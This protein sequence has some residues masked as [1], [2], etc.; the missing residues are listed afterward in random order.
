MG[1]AWPS[2]AHVHAPL[3]SP[4]EPAPPPV[5]PPPGTLQ[6]EGLLELVQVKPAHIVPSPRNVP[7]QPLADDPGSHTA[8][9]SASE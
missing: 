8:R 3:Q 4:P 1:E 6:V 2:Y 9:P 7:E 5:P